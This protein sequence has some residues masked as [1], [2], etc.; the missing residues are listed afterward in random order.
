MDGWMDFFPVYWLCRQLISIVITSISYGSRVISST[1][2]Q[3]I[4]SKTATSKQLVDLI[5]GLSLLGTAIEF[6]DIID[7]PGSNRNTSNTD[8]ST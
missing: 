5:G 4:G 7:L 2:A 6:P 1:V 3:V 8:R